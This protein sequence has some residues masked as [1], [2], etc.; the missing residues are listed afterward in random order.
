MRL[1]TSLYGTVVLVKLAMQS[2]KHQVKSIVKAAKYKA[3]VVVS[4]QKP[5]SCRLCSDSVARPLSAHLLVANFTKTGFTSCWT[6]NLK[7]CRPAIR[8]DLI[9]RD[10]IGLVAIAE[11]P[12]LL[13]M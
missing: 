12:C 11:H 1:L 13:T 6:S 2:K 10:V 9:I 5:A 4:S 7:T 8:F 3:A